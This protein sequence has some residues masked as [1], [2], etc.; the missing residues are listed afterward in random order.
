VARRRGRLA[1]AVERGQEAV[2]LFER[3]A[4]PDH[5]HLGLARAHAG[6]A[7]WAAGRADEGERALRA[8]VAALEHGFPDG[9]P[10]RAA[11]LF[12]L[13]EALARGG[14]RAEAREALREVLDWR[15]RHFGPSDPRSQ[16]VR[17]ALDPA[18]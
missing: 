5:P 3:A 14:R 15:E 18:R 13:G 1:P 7:L 11:A 2:A 4:G 9:H 8:G 12:L 16:A 6:A 10:D 17:R